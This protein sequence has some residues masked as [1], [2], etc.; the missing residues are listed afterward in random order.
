MVT[1][2]DRM[3]LIPKGFHIHTTDQGWSIYGTRAQTGT[4]KRKHFFWTESKAAVRYNFSWLKC[5]NLILIN[6]IGVTVDRAVIYVDIYILTY[7]DTIFPHQFYYHIAGTSYNLQHIL[8]SPAERFII[9]SDPT[10]YVL[11]I[12]WSFNNICYT[13]RW[14]IMRNGM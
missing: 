5:V 12:M 10:E 1:P 14:K 8:H 7:Q 4:Q 6:A 3:C 9:S 11:L 13:E 2:D